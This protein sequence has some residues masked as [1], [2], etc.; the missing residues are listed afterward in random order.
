MSANAHPSPEDPSIHL[1]DPAHESLLDELNNSASP[2]PQLR[3]ESKELEGS[4]GDGLSDQESKDRSIRILFPRKRDP[5]NGI[6]TNKYTPLTFVPLNLYE[7]FS[8][9]AN[10]YFLCVA[11]LQCIP[12]VSTTDQVPTILIPLCF[13]LLLTAIKDL[14]EDF[15]RYQS[16]REEN[17]TPTT[18]LIKADHRAVPWHQLKPGHVVQ[19]R[20]NETVPADLLLLY[21][22]DT[23]R[24]Q[25]F[26]ETRSLDG[27][28]N[29]KPIDQIRLPN[30]PEGRIPIDHILDLQ[31]SRVVYEREN[32]NLTS[33]SGILSHKDASVHLTIHNLLLRGCVLKNVDYIYGVVLYAGHQTRVM[34]N[35]VRTKMKKSHLE[36]WVGKW[37]VAIFGIEV[38]LCLFAALYHVLFL[39]FQS[40]SFQH[41]VSFEA[42]NMTVLFFTRFG[43][44][45]LIFG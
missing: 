15:R 35:S 40:P 23:H 44:W 42:A 19:L 1:Q 13:V 11:V 10:A 43:N 3:P 33:F 39:S 4:D 17:N 37:V 22:S 16:D 18:V 8:K 5:N 31:K 21:S 9:P 41:W 26:V 6:S 30:D 2:E 25:A 7:Q 34:Q 45:L 20:K 36:V 14:F 27:E 32:A 29:L 38:V 12:D 24:K 28:T